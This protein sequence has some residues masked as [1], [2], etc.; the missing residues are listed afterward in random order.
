MKRKIELFVGL[1]FGIGGT[2]GG[3]WILLTMFDLA[4]PLQ[5]SILNLVIQVCTIATFFMALLVGG[6]YMIYDSIKN[7]R[8]EAND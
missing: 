4:P 8:E 5:F 7:Y 1:V 6:P 2:V 3:W